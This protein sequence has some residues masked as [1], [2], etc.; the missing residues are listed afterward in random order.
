MNRPAW[1]EYLC[2]CEGC[3]ESWKDRLGPNGRTLDA[4]LILPHSK[5]IG[6]FCL[7]AKTIN[8]LWASITSFNPSV[9]RASAVIVLNTFLLNVKKKS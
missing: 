8:S 2:G 7:S 6:I 5:V 4:K 9:F 1:W 3:R